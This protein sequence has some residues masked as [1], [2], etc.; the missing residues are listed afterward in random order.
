MMLLIFH[1]S[2]F[3]TSIKKI[4]WR[5]KRS[6]PGMRVNFQ[7]ENI[8]PQPQIMAQSHRKGIWGQVAVSRDVHPVMLLSFTTQLLRAPLVLLIVSIITSDWDGQEL[9]TSWVKL[10][11]ER[12]STFSH[13]SRQANHSLTKI[14]HFRFVSHILH[15]FRRKKRLSWI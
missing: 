15:L 7:Q 9:N 8:L 10:N 2:T 1:R 12:S 4:F 3:E 6:N 5:V 11:I 13:L 14:A